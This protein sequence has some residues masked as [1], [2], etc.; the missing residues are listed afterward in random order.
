RVHVEWRISITICQ[1]KYL[2]IS[3]SNGNTN[4]NKAHQLYCSPKALLIRFYA[5]H[6]PIENCWKQEIASSVSATGPCSIVCCCT[7]LRNVRES[8]HLFCREYLSS[9][10]RTIEDDVKQVILCDHQLSGTF[11]LR[12][13]PTG[14]L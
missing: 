6:C 8:V 7:A 13:S 9:M 4:G 5:I 1:P 12:L 14:R 3:K 10:R 2:L 11:V